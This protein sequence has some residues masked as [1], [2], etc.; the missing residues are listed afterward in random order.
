MILGRGRGL[1]AVVLLGLGTLSACSGTDLSAAP[2]VVPA[3]PQL[4]ANGPGVE[5]TSGISE[6]D[7]TANGPLWWFTSKA[8]SLGVYNGTDEPATV[9]VSA[10]VVVPCKTPARMELSLP[11]GHRRT[12]K[13][14]TGRPGRVRF[15]VRIPAR[16][17]VDVGV[18]IEASAC[19]PGHDA[20]TLY[21][22]LL[23][24]RARVAG[25]DGEGGSQSSS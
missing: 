16:G 25:S 10:D 14:A 11:G 24:L 4:F 21:A 1:V 6:P 7:Q 23:S 18:R 13:A 5:V 19:R 22:G 2:D 3:R 17:E 12:A 15:A 20:R 8:G 9:R